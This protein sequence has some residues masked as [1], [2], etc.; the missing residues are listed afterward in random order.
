ME[1]N[2]MALTKGKIIGII[3]IILILISVVAIYSITQ[4]PEVTEVFIE[5]PDKYIDDGEAGIEIKSHIFI[6][7]SGGT[8]GSGKLEILYDGASVYSRSVDVSNSKGTTK[9]PWEDFVIGND[10]YTIKMTYEGVTGEET[11]YLSQFDWAV[12]EKVNITT[13][14]TPTQFTELNLNEIPK[15]K[16]G[17][18]FIDA[19]GNNLQAAVKELDLTLSIQYEDSTPFEQKVTPSDSDLEHN[20]Y[21]Y[22]YDYQNGGNYTI[23]ASVENLHISPDSKYATVESDTYKELINLEPL[24]VVDIEEATGDSLTVTVR[25]NQ[26]VHFDASRSRNDGDIIAYEWDF[27]FDDET[28]EFTVDATGAEVTHRFSEIGKTYYIA[29]RVRGDVFIKDPLD[30]L[31]KLQQEF[32]IN[33][34]WEVRVTLT[35]S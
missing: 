27:D 14:I 25:P 10:K 6:K 23:T 15:L 34:D 35:G 26:V 11:F 17:V 33:A 30:P 13:Q 12:C 1:A 3:I 9:I 21:S 5:R 28:Y 7:G 22:E 18:S 24:A 4:N 31:G 16:I 8:S 20:Y 2:I 29:L 32:N 19:K